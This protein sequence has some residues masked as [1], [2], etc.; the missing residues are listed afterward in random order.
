[1]Q[2]IAERDTNPIVQLKITAVET[3][4]KL[5]SE[6]TGK[7]LKSFAGYFNFAFSYKVVFLSDMKDLREEDFDIEPE[8]GVAINASFM[9]GNLISKPGCLKNLMTVMRKINLSIMVVSEVEGNHNSPTFVNRFIEAL[10]SSLRHYSTILL[11]LTALQK[12]VAQDKKNSM[13]NREGIHSIVAAEGYERV[14]R[15]VPI[16]VWRAFFA[17]FG[18]VELELSTASV[19]QACLIVEQFSCGKSCTLDTNSKCILVGWKGTPLY[20]ISSWKFN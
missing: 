13:E 17:R 20:S 12:G 1:M 5:R 14:T 18:L 6:T 3:I 10:F 4:D 11:Y 7:R 15:S 2:G 9:L 19:Y 16:S 8:E